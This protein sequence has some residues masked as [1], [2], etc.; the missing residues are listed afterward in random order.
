[1]N[2]LGIVAHQID[3]LFAGHR[4]IIPGT[5]AKKVVFTAVKRRRGLRHIGLS[6]HL[7]NIA[8][9]APLLKYFLEPVG[10]FGSV[11]GHSEIHNKSSLSHGFPPYFGIIGIIL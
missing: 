10:Y 7:Q 11:A 8:L 5:D 4:F 2:V 9:P 6:V 3:N 1:M